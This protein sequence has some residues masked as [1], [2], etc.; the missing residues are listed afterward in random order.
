MRVI[1]NLFKVCL[2]VFN[3]FYFL[4]GLGLVIGS[5]FVYMNPNQLNS[6]VKLEYGHEYTSLVYA[7]CAIGIFFILVGF[8][9]CLGILGEKSWLMFVYFCSLFAIFS[10]QF[11]CS[12]YIYLQSVNTF[13]SVSSRVLRVIREEYGESG[14]HARALDYLQAE[15]KCCGWY[16][17]RD[18]FDSSYV[19]PK[20]TL[21]VQPTELTNV[22]TISPAYFYKI[23]HSCCVNT[24][25]LTCL[26]MNKFHEVSSAGFEFRV[27]LN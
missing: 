11:T 21:R 27:N 19:D 12:V 20:Y 10:L 6:L 9:G 13:K 3:T 5:T 23:P 15:F 8:V 18:W 4:L 22:I 2:F 17:P 1:F 7:M 14:V 25:D 24:Y 26:L 16:S